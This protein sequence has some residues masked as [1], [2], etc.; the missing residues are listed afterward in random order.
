M[1]KTHVKTTN[2]HIHT[3]IKDRR[4]VRTE[5]EEILWS[6]TALDASVRFSV[7]IWRLP[8][9]TDFDHVDISKYPQEY[10]QAA[11]R[12]DRMTLEL[13]RREQDGTFAQ[14]VVG[15]GGDVGRAEPSETIEWDKFETKV[16]PDEVFDSGEAGQIFLAYFERDNVPPSYVLRRLTL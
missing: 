7:C 10:L 1:T 8:P 16:F 2:G 4:G 13:R 6:M 15:R 3:L 9:A 11:G 5:T 14:Y 12:A